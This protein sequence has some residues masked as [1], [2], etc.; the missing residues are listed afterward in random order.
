MI[1]R[2]TL[3][4]I[5]GYYHAPAREALTAPTNPRNIPDV[6]TAAIGSTGYF[7]GRSEGN[8]DP[9]DYTCEEMAHAIAEHFTI[10]LAHAYRENYTH[11]SAHG[12]ADRAHR[13][14]RNAAAL[15]LRP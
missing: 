8:G 5:I 1:P 4:G 2:D 14:M 12:A 7:H 6:I 15:A 10:A 11:G 9:W 13:I 3:T